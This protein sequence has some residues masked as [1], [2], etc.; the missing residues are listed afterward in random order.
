MT[1]VALLLS[2]FRDTTLASLW[3]FSVSFLR[4]ILVDLGDLL[5]LRIWAVSLPYPTRVSP[6]KV[7]RDPAQPLLPTTYC[8]SCVITLL[9]RL[10]MGPLLG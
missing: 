6:I 2:L 3:P 9:F 1:R 7:Y 5:C 8:V 10:G 4:R